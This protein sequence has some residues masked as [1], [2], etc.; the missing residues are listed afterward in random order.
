M[1]GK[2]LEQ[3]QQQANEVTK[4][5]LKNFDKVLEQHSDQLLDVGSAFGK[6]TETLAQ[7]CQIYLGLVV[8]GGLLIIQILRLAVFISQSS[9]SSSAPQTQD[10]GTASGSG[11]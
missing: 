6:T 3:C 1:A 10:A 7:H 8:G 4:I 11:A 2:E 5:M 9:D